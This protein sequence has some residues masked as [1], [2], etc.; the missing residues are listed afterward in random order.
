MMPKSCPERRPED[1][2]MLTFE[3]ASSLPAARGQPS[4][5]AVSAR[6]LL[7]GGYGRKFQVWPQPTPFLRSP[8]P[9]TLPVY[10]RCAP[11]RHRSR[12][13]ALAQTFSGPTRRHHVNQS[14]L[15]RI[16]PAGAL[17]CACERPHGL[18]P[19][20]EPA[21]C[22]ARG[23]K[24]SKSWSRRRAGA[25]GAHRACACRTTRDVGRGGASGQLSELGKSSLEFQEV[26]RRC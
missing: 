6:P 17:P 13:C 16:L 15:T 4:P 12:L 8:K 14:T 26:R 24:G 1:P 18:R 5:G 10:L 20:R 3:G 7:Q 9:P 25:G 23:P 22:R 19:G 11:H 21:A 2:T